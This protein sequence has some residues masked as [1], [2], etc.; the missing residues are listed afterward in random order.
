MSIIPRAGAKR[1][2]HIPLRLR[3]VYWLQGSPHI[4]IMAVVV[5]VALNLISMWRAGYFG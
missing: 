5:V 2:R 1:I 3:A 4:V